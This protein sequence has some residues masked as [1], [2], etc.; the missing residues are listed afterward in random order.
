MARLGKGQANGACSLLHAAGVGY[1]AS[2]AL[3]LPV[4]V[5]LLDK[6][7]RRELD[8][9]DGLLEATVGAWKE[10]GHE[11][12]GT[13]LHWS[14]TSKVPPRQGLKSSAAVSVAAIRAL[15]D[16]MDIELS[17]AE[18]VDISSKAQSSSGVSLTGSVDDAW[19]AAEGGWKLIDPNLPAAEG[20]LLEGDGPNS[21]DWNVLLVLRGE[22]L[23]SP[24]LETFAW[25]QQGF[26]KALAALEEGN[27][28]VALTWNGRSMASVLNDMMGRRLTNDAFV[29]G[30]RAAGISGTGSAIV[31]FSAS[32]STPTL[33]RL[34]MWYST[35]QDD[36]E[37][38]Q[39][40]VL[41]PQLVNV[42]EVE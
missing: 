28:L 24:E 31:I 17:N 41:N 4:V 12:P 35:R 3:D 8:D 26:Q 40:K 10:A 13:E 30:A 18:V 33:D 34:L 25:H 29:N 7:S 38:I 23:E 1:G 22:R 6:P 39:T 16:A 9:P 20:V 5:T 21:D 32:V 14:V 11:L 2:L 37:V 27:E 15:A 36:L 42:N 19:A